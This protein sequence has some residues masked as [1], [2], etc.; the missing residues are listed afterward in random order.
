MSKYSSFVVLG[1][2]FFFFFSDF[3]ENTNQ[4]V[5]ILGKGKAFTH[6]AFSINSCW[7]SLRTQKIH[8]VFKY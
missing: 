7:F 5:S 1:S 3:L 6:L 8:L 4:W 2:F